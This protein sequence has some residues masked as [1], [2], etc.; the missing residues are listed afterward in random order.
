MTLYDTNL[1]CVIRTPHNPLHPLLRPYEP[2]H[3]LA[4]TT[5]QHT[6]VHPCGVKS[7]GRWDRCHPGQ[8]A[9]ESFDNSH[10]TAKNKM[11]P[12]MLCMY[13]SMNDHFPDQC[14]QFQYF[15]GYGLW[16]CSWLHNGCAADC[17]ARR[18][19][20]LPCRQSTDRQSRLVATCIVFT[21]WHF[22]STSIMG[23]I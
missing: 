19:A 11:T 20:S 13:L 1:V 10:Q 17:A 12:P 8:L 22:L 9:K 16:P 3:K 15:H 2:S 18:A 5:Q 14:L 6:T 4:K 21:C 7:F 23:W